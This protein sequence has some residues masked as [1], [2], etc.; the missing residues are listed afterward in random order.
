MKE[1]DGN[2]IERAFWVGEVN[3]GEDGTS[4]GANKCPTDVHPSSIDGSKRSLKGF[5]EVKVETRA[6]TAK[7]RKW[8]R[9]RE[10]N[11]ICISPGNWHFLFASWELKMARLGT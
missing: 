3:N 11:Q 9:L 2:E 8:Q 10:S 1:A 6:I 7:Q 5:V 4:R